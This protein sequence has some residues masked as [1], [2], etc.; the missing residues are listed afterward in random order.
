M[1]CVIVGF[2]YQAAQIGCSGDV[3]LKVVSI[4]GCDGIRTYLVFDGLFI[5]N[6]TEMDIGAKKP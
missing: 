5:G 2:G 1:G 6:G 4:V 3:C